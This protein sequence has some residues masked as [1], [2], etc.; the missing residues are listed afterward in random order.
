MDSR[1]SRRLDAS[2]KLPPQTIIK[3]EQ[4]KPIN[5]V[6][7]PKLIIWTEH[8]TLKME[9]KKSFSNAAEVDEIGINKETASRI[10]FFYEVVLDNWT[11]EES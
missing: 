11:I 8:W 7:A 3:T 6:Y 9:V 1:D 5:Q 10:K 2:E 4:D